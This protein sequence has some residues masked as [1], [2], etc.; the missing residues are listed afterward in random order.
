MGDRKTPTP[1]PTNQRRP[2]PPPAPPRN[3]ADYES[4][5]RDGIQIARLVSVDVLGEIAHTR[6][7]GY[8]A[9]HDDAHSTGEL[10]DLVGEQLLQARAA[11][12]S[13]VRLDVRAFLVKTAATAIA[14]IASLDRRSPS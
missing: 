10:L 12:E 3:R 8:D 11:H 9:N 14:A 2:D 1:L 4:N 5:Y 7:L 13:H 6:T